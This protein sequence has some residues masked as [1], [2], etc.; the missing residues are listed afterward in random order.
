MHSEYVKV[1]ESSMKFMFRDCSTIIPHRIAQDFP[2]SKN[3]LYVLTLHVIG[4]DLGFLDTDTHLY[5]HSQS[6]SFA[7]VCAFLPDGKH[8]ERPPSHPAPLTDMKRSMRAVSVDVA[9]DNVV[10]NDD[11]GHY[12]Y[13]D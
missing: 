2:Q 1:V 4:S 13:E 7:C 12:D 11:C 6:Q 10:A 9:A 8:H 3:K 5:K